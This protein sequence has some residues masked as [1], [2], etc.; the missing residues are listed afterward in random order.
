MI[1]A[2]Y[3]CGIGMKKYLLLFFLLIA[4]CSSKHRDPGFTSVEGKWT[5]TTPDNKIAVTFELA[6][7]SGNDLVIQNQTMKI[8]GTS[9]NSFGQIIAGVLPAIQKIRI[10]ANDAAAVYNYNI[11]FNNCS[12]S[13]DFKTIEVPTATYTWPWPT[14]NTLSSVKITRF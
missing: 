4:G 3:I 1:E 6:K 8:D 12:V 14:V 13:T 9:Y 7:T 2:D 11:E 5:Y 10:N